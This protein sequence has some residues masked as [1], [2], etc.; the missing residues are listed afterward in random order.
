MV[1]QISLSP[2]LTQTS[3]CSYCQEHGMVMEAYSPLGTGRILQL[4]EMR[5]FAEK[6]N[7]SIAQICIRWSLQMGF[8]PLPMLQ[9]FV[10]ISMFLILSSLMKMFRQLFRLR[11]VVL[12]E[13]R[14]QLTFNVIAF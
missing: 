1:N 7:H 9:E 8:I 6:Y 14:I 4:E 3:M 2:G 11:Q 5:Y 13:I 10:K 12:R